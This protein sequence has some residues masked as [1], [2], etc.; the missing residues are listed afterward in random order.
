MPILRESNWLVK[1]GQSE[2]YSKHKP[3]GIDSQPVSNPFTAPAYNLPHEFQKIYAQS[4]NIYHSRPFDCGFNDHQQLCL[5]V[6]HAHTVNTA[7]I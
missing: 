5:A 4:K 1:H 6:H 2:L 7:F 3:P